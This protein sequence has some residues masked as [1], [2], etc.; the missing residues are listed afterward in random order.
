[1]HGFLILNNLSEGNPEKKK[2]K[3]QAPPVRKK[4][5]SKQNKGTMGGLSN[6]LSISE[7]QATPSMLMDTGSSTPPVSLLA[8]FTIRKESNAHVSK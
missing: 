2:R 4:K 5:L 8:N 6:F 7:F 3:G 1:M